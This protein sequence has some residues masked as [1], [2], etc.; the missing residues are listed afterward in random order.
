M[1][2]NSD[3]LNWPKAVATSSLLQSEVQSLRRSGWWSPMKGVLVEPQRSGAFFSKQD[4]YLGYAKALVQRRSTEI[5][6]T[7]PV[8]AVM[9]GHPVWPALTNIDVY[10]SKGR[11]EIRDLEPHPRLRTPV[12]VRPMRRPDSL[13]KAYNLGDGLLVAT[14]EQIAVDVARLAASESAFITVCSI[15]GRLATSGNVYQDRGD[16]AL[17]E[18]EAAAR[19]RMLTI[20]GCLSNTAGRRRAQKIISLASGQVE[21]LAEARVLWIIRAYKLPA[22]MMQYRIDVNGKTFFGDF[23]WPEEKLIV[24]FNG[25]GK[26]G[27]DE[28]KSKRVADERARESLLRSVGYE[29]IN[30]SWEQLRDHQYIASLIITQLSRRSAIYSK[31]TGEISSLTVQVDPE[32]FRPERKLRSDSRASRR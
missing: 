6:F 7:G 27:D 5:I 11:R 16:A 2:M 29:V 4:C 32:L 22:P 12:H 1:F 30:L 24:E 14:L 18:R 3:P 23:V 17:L 8:A 20:A 15:L 21:S 28:K 26:Y 9:L 25:E 19:E 10:R 13:T 31:K